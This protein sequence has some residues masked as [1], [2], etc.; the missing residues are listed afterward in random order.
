M[1]TPYTNVSGNPECVTKGDY[2]FYHSQLRIRV[3]CCFEMLVQR[4]GRL[5]MAFHH[6]MS[7]SRIVG[8]VNCLARLHNFCC[9]ETDRLKYNEALSGRLSIDVQHMMENRNGYVVSWKTDNNEV[10]PSALLSTDDPFVGVF[11][12]SSEK[13]IHLTSSFTLHAL[14]DRLLFTVVDVSISDSYYCY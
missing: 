1:A 14:G 5:R 2:N 12:A 8:L 13:Q 3:K 4:W 11:G 7:I 6:S 10:I 9:S